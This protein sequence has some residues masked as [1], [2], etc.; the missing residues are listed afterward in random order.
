MEWQKYPASPVSQ[1]FLS[2]SLA[3]RD[4]FA[5]ASRG[6]I[7]FGQSLVDYLVDIFSILI[8]NLISLNSAKRVGAQG[9]FASEG[10]YFLQRLR[11]KVLNFNRF[12]L[13]GNI[14]LDYSQLDLSSDYR[15][16]EP[17]ILGASLSVSN[18]HFDTLIL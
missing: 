8:H 15:E 2:G 5:A 10:D 7:R 17:Y 14:H 16:Q 12:R 1:K 11:E 9:F 18:H 4:I 3:P 6:A 13:C